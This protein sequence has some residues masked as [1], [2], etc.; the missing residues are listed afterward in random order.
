MALFFSRCALLEYGWTVN[1]SIGLLYLFI[2]IFIVRTV[3]ALHLPRNKHL[4]RIGVRPILDSQ[5]VHGLKLLE[6]SVD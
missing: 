2:C 1:H 4:L 3:Q 6:T 5:V